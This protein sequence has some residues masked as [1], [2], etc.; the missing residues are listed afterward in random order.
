[1]P[2]IAIVTS[3]LTGR[4]FASFELASRLQREGH[5]ITYL[6][7]PSTQEKIEE[8]GFK[9]VPVSEITFAY[10][11]PRRLAM[12]SGWFKKLLFHYKNLNNHYSEGK[13]ILKLEEHKEVLRKVSPDLILIDNEIHD[14]IFTAWELKIPMK[15]TTDWFSDKISAN[16]PSIRTSVIPGE[17]V[18]GT[19]IGV[20]FSWFVLRAKIYGRV[21]INKVTFE[22]YRRSV[23]KKYALEIGFETSGL[24][25]NTLPPPYSFKKLPIVTM[26]MS[27]LEFPHKLAKNFTYIGPMVYENRLFGNEFLTEHQQ[28]EKIFRIK[29]AS[30]KKLIY[31]SV[32]SL[33]E[34]YLPFLRK[35]I[36][37]VANVDSL[38]LIMSIGPKMNLESF[39]Y[40]P[41]NV[42]LFNWVPQL[43]VLKNADCC[44]T[45]CGINSINECIHHKVPML[46][47]SGRY[48]DE[49][50]NAAR[51]SY[52]GLGI[53][54]DILKDSSALIKDNIEKVLTDETF[55]HK[56]NEFNRL[57]LDYNS[58]PLTPLLFDF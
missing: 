31:C 7:Q 13:K 36:D 3:L 16:S 19:K 34:G 27:E 23:L 43:D 38:L 22:N 56:V 10:Q 39:E 37:A 46:L 40:I 50:G 54:G 1:M 47:Y 5:S 25:V 33:A 30:N 58:R 21:L 42:H 57:Y 41:Q 24:L 52:H 53:R 6:C 48:T 9:C 18:S 12:Q 55:K 8:K 49:N 14:L 28:L 2:H 26:S 20:L 51:M 11:D 15:L 35:V 32:G 45:H 29:S 4:L 17:G 44:I